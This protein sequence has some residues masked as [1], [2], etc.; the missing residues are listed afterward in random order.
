MGE[1]CGFNGEGGAGAGSR[2]AASPEEV[3]AVQEVCG[4]CGWAEASRQV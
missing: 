2:T 4:P 1:Q 3:R